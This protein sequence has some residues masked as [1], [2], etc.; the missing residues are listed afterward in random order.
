MKI[1]IIIPVHNRK[2]IT[3]RCLERLLNLRLIGVTLQ[4]VIIDDGSTDGTK[5]AI[6]EAFPNT[7]VLEGDGNLWWSGS[8]NMGILY[9]LNNNYDYVLTLNDDIDFENNFLNV[10]IETSLAYPNSI[11]GSI[12]IHANKSERRILGAGGLR[13]GFL[14]KDFVRILKDSDYDR[15]RI[16]EIIH[17]DWISGYSVLLPVAIFR[18]IGIYDQICFPQYF[19]DADITLRAKKAGYGVIVNTRSIVYVNENENY[20]ENVLVNKSVR[21]IYTSCFSDKSNFSI[22]VIYRSSMRYTP[23]KLGLIVFILR[24]IGL[25]K[26]ITLR[27]VLPRRVFLKL[28]MKKL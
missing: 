10:L 16:P 14:R 23:Y 5:I 13:K 7:I 20:F 27:T 19:C 4:I 28:I 25:F 6:E 21:Q 24:T 1:A 18:D 8:V 3:L 26:W 9:A 11:I 15:A 22:V 12:A 17:V 2:N